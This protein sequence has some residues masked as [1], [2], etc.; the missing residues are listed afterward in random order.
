MY[1]LYV[2]KQHGT[3]N[4]NVKKTTITINRCHFML[5]LK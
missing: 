4:K 5:S 3:N 1:K 2:Q